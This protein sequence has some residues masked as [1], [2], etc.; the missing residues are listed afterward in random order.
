M[1]TELRSFVLLEF[2]SV[3]LQGD[4]DV[5]PLF[6]RSAIEAKLASGKRE[7]VLL[8]GSGFVALPC[9][10]YITRNPENEL[11]IGE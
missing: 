7:K 10:E 1:C 8:L 9:A 4:N 11:I 5:R 6:G 3:M 2:G